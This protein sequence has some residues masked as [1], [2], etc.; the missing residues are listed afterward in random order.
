M[1]ESTSCIRTDSSEPSTETFERSDQS[2]V[3][4]TLS[5]S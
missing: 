2:A 1:T 4:L 5:L 3:T